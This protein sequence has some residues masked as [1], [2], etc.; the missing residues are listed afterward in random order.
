VIDPVQPTRS[1]S[2]VDGISGQSINNSRTRGSNDTNDVCVGVRSYRGGTSG[3]TTL[4][5]VVRVIPNRLAIAAFGSPSSASRRINAQSS[6][7]ITLQS[8]SVHF[9]PS[10]LSSFR[11]SST[12]RARVEVWSAD[13]DTGE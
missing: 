9:S 10:E 4:P 13:R 3:A 7:V 2:T 1:A 5:T 8:S 12:L 6:K 11:A